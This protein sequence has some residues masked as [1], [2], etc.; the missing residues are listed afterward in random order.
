LI[1]VTAP[2]RR[3]LAAL[4]LLPPLPTGRDPR[5]AR[6]PRARPRTAKSGRA[7][8]WPR[9]APGCLL[10]AGAC[11]YRPLTQLA[12]I[13]LYGGRRRARACAA[14]CARAPGAGGG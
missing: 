12:D 14:P 7:Q 10:P 1:S 5:R 2:R 6:P 8:P 4:D 11:G 13:L 9:P 3:P